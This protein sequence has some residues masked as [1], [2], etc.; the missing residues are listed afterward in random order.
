MYLF[1]SGNFQLNNQ[2]IARLFHLIVDKLDFP[3]QKLQQYYEDFW[4]LV[5]QINQ[6]K[7]YLEDNQFEFD[8]SVVF[9]AVTLL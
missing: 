6:Q 2:L 8:S 1:E 7:F 4:Q 3:I 9:V 5:L